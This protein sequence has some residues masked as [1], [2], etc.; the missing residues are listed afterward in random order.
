VRSP[1]AFLTT[2]VTRMSIDRLR[3]ARHRRESYV[4]PWLPEPIV[5]RSPDPADIVAEAEHFSLAFLHSMESLAPVERAVLLLREGFDYDYTE[6]ADIVGKSPANCRQI[7]SRARGH[8]H[9][10]AR[11]S[12]GD[13]EGE[14]E[15]VMAA[16]EAVR[17]A[18]VDG[19]I[20]VLAQDIVAWSDGGPNRRAARNPVIGAERVARFLIGI[21]R[22]SVGMDL[23]A[24]PVTIGGDPGVRL[25]IGGAI[26]G[27]MV[28]RVVE[29]RI[30]A[31]RSVVNPDKLS[32]VG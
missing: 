18:D 1:L 27:V 8:V 26:Y 7:A 25:D 21:A 3:S 2:M 32:W 20:D 9:E 5:E 6:I 22:Q 10:P 23:S 24:T 17:A 12:G 31:I 28:F 14:R 29:N 13:P 11:R 16:L 15:V 19:L 30:Q 4:G